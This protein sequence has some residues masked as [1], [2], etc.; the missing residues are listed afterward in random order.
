M[1]RKAEELRRRRQPPPAAAYATV[2]IEELCALV[3]TGKGRRN[4]P[5]A[6]VVDSEASNHICSERRAF[7]SLRTLSKPV[8]ITLGDG[9]KVLAKAKG[10]I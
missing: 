2:D 7:H 4:I 6:W 9:N 10:M 3:T 8:A 5:K 1:R